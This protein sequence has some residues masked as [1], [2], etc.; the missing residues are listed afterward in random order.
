MFPVDA[1]IFKSYEQHKWNLVCFVGWVL[2]FGLL[3]R[4]QC[5]LD[6]KV[7][8]DLGDVGRFEYDQNTSYT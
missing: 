4:I 6:K 8:A 7:E 1:N 2:V 3:L 5:G